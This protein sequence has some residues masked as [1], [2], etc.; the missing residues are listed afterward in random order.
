MR[1]RQI[2][3]VAVAEGEEGAEE[4]EEGEHRKGRE[5]SPLEAK[6]LP[7]DGSVAERAEPEEVNP[8]GNGG[9]AAN[10]DED[11]ERS[12]WKIKASLTRRGF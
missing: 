11:D 8:I 10:K 9:A 4:D 5:G 6:G 3:G 1:I 7:E 12:D 2:A